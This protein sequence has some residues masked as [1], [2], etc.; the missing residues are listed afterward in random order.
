MNMHNQ[1]NCFKCTWCSSKFNYKSSYNRHL[2][3]HNPNT[4]L[5]CKVCGKNFQRSD[6]LRVHMR[7]KHPKKTFDGHTNQT[8]YSEVKNFKLI[9]G[10]NQSNVPGLLSMAEFAAKIKRGAKHLTNQLDSDL[11]AFMS[12]SS[13]EESLS[14]GV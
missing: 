7:V 10:K 9:G 8:L 6:C 4:L 3:T 5:S 12:D 11:V 14:S 1:V 13:E 2:K